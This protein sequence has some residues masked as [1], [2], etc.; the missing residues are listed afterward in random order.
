MSLRYALL[1]PQM[2][3]TYGSLG[4]PAIVHGVTDQHVL[5]AVDLTEYG[6]CVVMR[7]RN[8]RSPTESRD[9]RA[10]VIADRWLP[11]SPPEKGNTTA[12]RNRVHH[13]CRARRP[14]CRPH[15]DRPGDASL[16]RRGRIDDRE[17]EPD[18]EPHHEPERRNLRRASRDD[19]AFARCGP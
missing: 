10:Q 16:A 5:I 8:T 13:D 4:R 7:I 3:H 14:R 18:R 19:L 15:A 1:V 9:D 6:D 2:R 17:R 12:Q 11:H